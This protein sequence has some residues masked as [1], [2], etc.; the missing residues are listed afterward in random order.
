M[1]KRAF[2]YRFHPTDGQRESLAKTFGCTRVVCDSILHG[3]SDAFDEDDRSIGYVEASAPLSEIKRSG[4]LP[5]LN[6]VSSVPPPQCLRHRRRACRD[7]V[8]GRARSTLRRG[9]LRVPNAGTARAG[10]GTPR[11]SARSRDC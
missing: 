3:R 5:R 7:I 1:S 9:C 2:T 10:A 8:E 11:K 6:E 4:E